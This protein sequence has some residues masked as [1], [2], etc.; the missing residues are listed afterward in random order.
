DFVCSKQ[1]F[2][3]KTLLLSKTVNIIYWP[4]CD[5]SIRHCGPDPQPQ[6]STHRKPVV[7]TEV[8]VYDLPHG[9]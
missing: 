4:Y 5:A 9:H 1:H 2:I 6:S 3:M 8:E 7:D